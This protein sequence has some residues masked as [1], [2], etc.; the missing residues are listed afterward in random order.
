MTYVKLEISAS[1]GFSGFWSHQVAAEAAVATRQ[2]GL[3][4]GAEEV[5][6]LP[7]TATT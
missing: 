5:V 1:K 2:I 4:I 6:M 3:S 7:L